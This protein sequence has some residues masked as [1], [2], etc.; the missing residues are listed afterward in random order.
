MRKRCRHK[1]ISYLRPSTC[2]L[3]GKVLNYVKADGGN[4]RLPPKTKYPLNGKCTLEFR[5][6]EGI[7]FL[8]M[9]LL[10]TQY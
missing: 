6:K 5:S 4:F 2:L 3:I 10:Y 9:N 1:K 8:D 7:R